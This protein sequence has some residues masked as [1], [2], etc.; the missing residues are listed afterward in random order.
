MGNF[1]WDCVVCNKS[2]RHMW[3]DSG[4]HL[5]WRQDVVIFA[6]DGTRVEGAYTGYGGVVLAGGTTFMFPETWDYEN[7]VFWNAIADEAETNARNGREM[8]D[9]MSRDIDESKD[10]EMTRIVGPFL[11]KDRERQIEREATAIRD[12]ERANA[13]AAKTVAFTAYH[14]RCWKRAGQPGFTVQ[15]KHSE[16]GGA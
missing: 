9:A 1:S 6:A 12:R 4:K 16:D 14:R 15:S 3:Q 8:I 13:M 11:V 7:L 5:A 2:M 10:D